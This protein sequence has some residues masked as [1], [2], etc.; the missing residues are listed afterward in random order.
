MIA[1]LQRIEE[2]KKSNNP[3]FAEIIHEIKLTPNIN[4]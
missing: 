3:D 1:I 2:I 4:K